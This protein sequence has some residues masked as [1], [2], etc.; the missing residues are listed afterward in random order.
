MIRFQNITTRSRITENSTLLRIYAWKVSLKG[1][2]KYPIGIGGNQF[3]YL[4]QQYSPLKNITLKHSHNFILGTAIEYGIIS[5]VGILGIFIKTIGNLIKTAKKHP[6]NMLLV[7]GLIGFLVSATFSE[8]PRCH[9][10]NNGT[11]LI[12]AYSLMF[13]ALSLI[14]KIGIL[15]RKKESY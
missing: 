2:L 6:E 9:I 10:K 15:W 8:G 13:V 4:W 1:L 7:I 14:T 12:T 3:P 5:A 11:I